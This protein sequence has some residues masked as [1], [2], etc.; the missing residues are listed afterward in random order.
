MHAG[1]V[2]DFSAKHWDQR[3]SS[4]CFES[5]IPAT[6]YHDAQTVGPK[7]GEPFHLTVQEAKSEDYTTGTTRNYH[8][9]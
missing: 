7:A 4:K 3:S 2:V 6:I 1:G 5:A 8:H 9:V